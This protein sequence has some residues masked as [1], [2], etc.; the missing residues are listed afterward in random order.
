[1]LIASL[2][3]PY[4]CSTGGSSRPTS[5]TLYFAFAVQ[6]L[7]A[8]ITDVGQTKVEL[9]QVTWGVLLG[10]PVCLLVSLTKF[11][12]IHFPNLRDE[13]VVY[14]LRLE[15]AFEVHGGDLLGL[16]STAQYVFAHPILECCEKPVS[17]KVAAA[18]FFADFVM[19]LHWVVFE[20]SWVFFSRS[21]IAAASRE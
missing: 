18:A 5:V 16:E 11:A 13:P 2:W 3:S 1:V 19:E 7:S 8:G 4:R 14:L 20:V 9:A 15:T 6:V 10:L 21:I 17:G 12:L